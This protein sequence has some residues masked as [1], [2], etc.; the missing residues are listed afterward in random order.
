MR[1]RI[2]V[3]IFAFYKIIEI[4]NKVKEMDLRDTFMDYMGKPEIDRDL[5]WLSKN[6]G[7]SYSH[8][9]YVFIKKERNLTDETTGKINNALGTD[10]K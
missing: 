4:M 7:I 8:L 1:N 10:F 2:F 9:Y 3:F 5:V 6:T